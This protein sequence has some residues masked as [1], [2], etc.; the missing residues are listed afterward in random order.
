MHT[1]APPPIPNRLSHPIV[2][3]PTPMSHRLSRIEENIRTVLAEII[4]HRVRDPRMPV[5]FTITGV[6]TSPDLTDAYVYFSQMPDDEDAIDETLD[7][8]DSA[9][10]FLRTALSRELNLRKTPA[11]NFE[12]DAT[13][14]RANRIE[15]LLAENLPPAS[16]GDDEPEEEDNG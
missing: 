14:A 4:H 10:G 12:Y 6:K 11:L 1:T 9:A 13:E 15:Q 2:W 3:G 7:A 16:A 8:L 5:I